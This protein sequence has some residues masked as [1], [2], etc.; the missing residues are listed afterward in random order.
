MVLAP[1]GVVD[2]QLVKLARLEGEL[3]GVIR[4]LLDAVLP[5]VQL[6]GGGLLL[7][8]VAASEDNGYG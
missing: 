2:Y 1:A 3:V 6:Y 4:M 5:Q 8:K 7:G